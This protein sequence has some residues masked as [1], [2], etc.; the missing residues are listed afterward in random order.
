[1]RAHKR[2][3]KVEQTIA[4]MPIR[5][6]LLK[7]SFELFRETGSLPDDVR[8]GGEVINWAETGVDPTEY[9]DAMERQAATFRGIAD[10]IRTG[11]NDKFMRELRREAVYGA[12]PIRQLARFLLEGMAENGQDP[13]G[14]VILK[15]G[16]PYPEWTCGSAAFS[17]LGWPYSRVHASYHAQLRRVMAEYERIG[18]QVGELSHHEQDEWYERLVDAAEEH[19]RTGVFPADEL[20]QTMMQLD[21]EFVRIG[22]EGR[23]ALLAERQAKDDGDSAPGRSPLDV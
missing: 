3:Q 5:A 4:A 7:R 12:G 15:R 22:R 9:T 23:A 6:D 14:P 18:K 16:P 17:I 2:M 8:L 19:Q 11:A 13:T 10:Q 1:M 21:A 20:L